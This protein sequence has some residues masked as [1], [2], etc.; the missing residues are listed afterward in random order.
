M[1][2]EAVRVAGTTLRGHPFR[3]ALTVLSVTIGA[4]SIVVMMSLAEA[5]QS[6]LSRSIEEVGGMRMIMWIPD[7]VEEHERAIYDDG[8][9]TGDLNAMRSVPHLAAAAALAPY[10]ESRVVSRLGKEQDVDVVGVELEV[11]DLLAWPVVSG[12]PLMPTDLEDRRRVAVLT[13]LVASDLYGGDAVGQ[14]INLLGK[15]YVVVGVLEERHPTGLHFGFDWEQSAFIPLYTAELHEGQSEKNR[16]V[17][18]RT[19]DA[20]NNAQVVAVANAKLLSRHRSVEDF[21]VIDFSRILEEFYKFFLIL[22]ALVALIAGI[23]LFA[24]GVGVM[25][26]ML[27]AVSERVK[28][29]GIR[30]AVG[31]SRRSIL[32]QFI[33]E[34]S[35]VSTLGG[36]VGAAA[37]LGATA[38]AHIAIAQ[39]Q[40]GWVAAYSWR[41]LLLSL[42]VTTSIGLTFGAIPAWRASRLDIVECL[43]R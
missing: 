18:G 20:R 33:V 38:L 34:A 36:L 3:T 39:A 12:R 11:L 21:Q 25:N 14:T 28:E 35:V 42:S 13:H 4:F 15:P 9:T 31:A 2:W 7:D 17:I 10:G 24:G 30:K 16:Y 8:L 22:D 37:G 5:G 26:I 41:G 43:R 29:I 19:D 40:E 27:V 32:T 6:T 23:S 1:I